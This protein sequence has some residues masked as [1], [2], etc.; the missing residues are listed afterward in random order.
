MQPIPVS[1]TESVVHAWLRQINVSFVPG[2]MTP[3]LEQA[4]ARLLDAFRTLGHTVQG[5][6]DEHTDLLLTT[7]PFAQPLNWRE[8]LLFTARRR[9]ALPHS[10]LSV[11]LIHARP[12]EFRKLME[13]FEAALRKEPRDPAD[14][15]FEG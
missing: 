5:Q 8:S 10:P 11:T 2:V 7:A 12:E 6:P 14:F 15:A 1:P 4:A 9:F 13:H 3:L